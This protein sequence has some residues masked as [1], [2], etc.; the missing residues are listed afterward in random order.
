MVAMPLR[1]AASVGQ[2]LSPVGT[3]LNLKGSDGGLGLYIDPR[4]RVI[5]RLDAF[6]SCVH[7]LEL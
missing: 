6:R 4:S 2:V 1:F 7:V 5:I 3:E